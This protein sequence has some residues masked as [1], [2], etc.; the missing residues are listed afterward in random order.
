MPRETYS[1]KAHTLLTISM[2]TLLLKKFETRES[3]TIYTPSEYRGSCKARYCADLGD[4][5][6]S[7]I[8]SRDTFVSEGDQQLIAGAKRI[9]CPRL[10]RTRF[11]RL[12]VFSSS[13][14]EWGPCNRSGQSRRV[15]RCTVPSLSQS[16][17]VIHSYKYGRRWALRW[18]SR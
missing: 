13:K 15:L 5:T 3:V 11:R 1:V 4:T 6:C 12:E 9:F 10:G 17:S 7:S 8:G 14:R 2:P 16:R 18:T